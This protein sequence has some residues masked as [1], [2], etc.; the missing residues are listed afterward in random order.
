[1][2]RFKIILL[3][4]LALIGYVFAQGL[5]WSEPVRLSPD[6]I[7]AK[8]QFA[9]PLGGDSI[10]VVMYF[11]DPDTFGGWVYTRIWSEGGLGP[12]DSVFYDVPA[13]SYMSDL[14][15][16]TGCSTPSGTTWIFGLEANMRAYAAYNNGSGWIRSDPPLTGASPP[17]T[18]YTSIAGPDGYP[19]LFEGSG[20]GYIGYTRWDG[21][22]WNSWE[23]LTGV[24]NDGF[25][26]FARNYGDSLILW[27]TV[28]TWDERGLLL[29]IF[30][31]MG[32]W[33]AI[34][35][36]FVTDLTPTCQWPYET[37]FQGNIDSVCFAAEDKYDSDD[38][39]EYSIFYA[40][41]GI[42]T[43]VDTLGLKSY[44]F[45]VE[46]T[47]A[48]PKF[49][50]DSTNTTW[51]SWQSGNSWHW[52]ISAFWNDTHWIRSDSFFRPDYSDAFYVYTADTLGPMYVLW[53]S[54][55]GARRL[56]SSI[57]ENSPSAKP[58]A[59]S[60]STYP[61]PFNSAITIS[62]S[63]IPG[64]TRPYGSSENPEIEIFDIAGRLVAEIP[65]NNPVGEGLRPSRSSQNQK[66]GGSETA[67]LQNEVVWTPDESLAS[68]VYLVRA[69][70]GTE[71][72]AKRL[73]YLK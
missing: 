61:N 69:R 6:S 14:H 62:I 60:L 65:A 52:L 59:L 35:T 49:Y 12:I 2:E 66:T 28:Q 17:L 40:F 24:K 38:S 34:E 27:S 10:M 39:T 8:A 1:M 22:S 63:V 32:I 7:A 72:I 19:W 73:V 3:F 15:Y 41:C 58:E 55:W 54:S 67:P 47:N 53:G 33:S 43:F 70:I 68:G 18:G 16:V 44:Y 20:W 30:N 48:N 31:F 13:G 50:L 45:P 9:I 21:I 64:L 57:R 29:K 42:D 4:V 11:D 26:M 36:V 5:I 37:I 25:E 51:A 46:I 71:S 23:P 56:P